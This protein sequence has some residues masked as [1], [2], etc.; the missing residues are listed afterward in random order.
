M[1]GG[2]REA[3]RVLNKKTRL[4]TLAEIDALLDSEAPMKVAASIANDMSPYG[5][6]LAEMMRRLHDLDGGLAEAVKV[7]EQQ[8]ANK[9]TEP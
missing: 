4:S 6:A 8:H 7:V 1:G 3:K 5:L 9:K 2:S